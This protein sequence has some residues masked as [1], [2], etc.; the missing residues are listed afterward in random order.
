MDRKDLEYELEVLRESTEA[1]IAKI[2]EEEWSKPEQ[3]T[4]KTE[5]KI[6]ND[7]CML[8]ALYATKKYGCSGV[9]GYVACLEC[10]FRR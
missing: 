3:K 4:K 5:K 9:E 10:P 7:S 6:K 8:K 2:M 1:W